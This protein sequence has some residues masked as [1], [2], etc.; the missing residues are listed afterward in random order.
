M[1]GPFQ[2][3]ATVAL[4]AGVNIAFLRFDT[5]SWRTVAFLVTA[6]LLILLLR[7]VGLAL[8]GHAAGVLIDG[9][10][11]ISLDRLQ[12][13]AWTVLTTAVLV[14]AAASNLAGVGGPLPPGT[15]PLDI[16]IPQ[17]L[18][19]ALGISGA[20]LAASPLILSTRPVA[21]PAPSAALAAAGPADSAA[22]FTR[23]TSQ[24]ADWTDIVQGEEVGNA[25][26]VDLGKVQQI[27]F[28]LLVLGAYTAEV[29]AAFRV[30]APVTALPEPSETFLYLM[31]ISHASYLAY[32]GVPKTSARGGTR[33]AATPSAP[34]P[35]AVAGPG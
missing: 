31:G 10:N 5:V 33:A 20:T 19:A 32:K 23:E 3:L 29:F 4:I 27:F 2:L 15:S 25:A 21:D 17:F 6:A 26:T 16:T 35:D 11:R 24:Q 28:T 14:V 22:V 18:L 1:R 12:V 13:M 9:R 8:T 7:Q 30:D 34:A